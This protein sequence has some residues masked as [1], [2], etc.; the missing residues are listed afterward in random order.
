MTLD[1]HMAPDGAEEGEVHIFTETSL[2]GSTR[3]VVCSSTGW[4][5]KNPDASSEISQRLFIFNI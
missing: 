4:R 2:V 1:S 5:E 3:H